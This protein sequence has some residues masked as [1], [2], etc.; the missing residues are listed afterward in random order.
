MKRATRT[1][2]RRRGSGRRAT[3]VL[4]EEDQNK[5]RGKILKA[6][7][8]TLRASTQD[9]PNRRYMLVKLPGS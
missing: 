1:E 6:A 7:K 3:G 9:N 4:E 2:G 5:G 8:L